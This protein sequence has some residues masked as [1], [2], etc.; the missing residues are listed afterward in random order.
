MFST[1]SLYNVLEERESILV[2]SDIPIPRERVLVN[3]VDTS[4]F[5]FGHFDI[6]GKR[7]L[8]AGRD[9]VNIRLR[10]T[11]FIEGGSAVARQIMDPPGS[12]GYASLVLPSIVPSF[13]IRIMCRRKLWDFTK[14]SYSEVEVPLLKSSIDVAVIRLLFT[15]QQ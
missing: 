12:N 15:L 1:K 2:T 11:W 6:A 7:A 10:D 4:R 8:M 13:N 14:N 5:V 9:V 3:G